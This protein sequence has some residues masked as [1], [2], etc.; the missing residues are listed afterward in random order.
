MEILNDRVVDGLDT[1]NIED[2]RRTGH[3]FILR[4]DWIMNWFMTFLSTE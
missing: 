3:I 2:A 4:G 1:K